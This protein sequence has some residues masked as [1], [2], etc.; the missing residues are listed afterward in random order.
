MR[1]ANCRP[2]LL[3]LDVVA[4]SLLFCL[5][6]SVVALLISQQATVAKPAIPEPPVAVP[7]PEPAPEALDWQA[8]T[9]KTRTLTAQGES[10]ARLNEAIENKVTRSIAEREN[11]VLSSRIAEVGEQVAMLES[12]RKA[13]ADATRIQQALDARRAEESRT[14]TSRQMLG[15]YRGPY[16]L[17]ECVEG[18][19]I[20]YPGKERIALKPPQAQVD[21]LVAKIVEA[22]FVVFVVR[23]AGWYGD[24]YDDLRPTIYKALANVKTPD[25]KPIGRST[26][27]LEASES[28]KEY[29][30]TGGRA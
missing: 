6:A 4:L 15:D 11:L 5:L 14:A 27:P 18:A 7:A 23:P 22:G 30:P 8:L 25:G 26:F 21:A 12:L 28:I 3:N 1:T 16:V 10:A 13:L 9:E 19:S 24:S 20:V 2:A 17:I 29:L